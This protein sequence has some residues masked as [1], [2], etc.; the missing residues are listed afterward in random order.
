MS[1]L[2]HVAGRARNVAAGDLYRAAA[3]VL[4]RMAAKDGRL[5]LLGG[6]EKREIFG[7]VD[8]AGNRSA[9][10]IR[11]DRVV[12]SGLASLGLIAPGEDGY[13]I[14][15]EGVMWLRRRDAGAEP[16][17]EQHQD[18]HQ[19]MLDFAGTMR[20]VVMNAGE[21]PI[22]WLRR[23]KDRQGNALI[24]AAQ[25]EAG[26]RLRADYERGQLAPSTTSNW[27]AMA[28]SRRQRRSAPGG[29]SDLSDAALAARERFARALDAVG[30]ELSGVLIDICCHLAGLAET[31]KNNG[32]P[33]RSG[34]VILQLALSQ[35]ARH[36]GIEGQAHPGN[37]KE[38]ARLVHW[39]DEGYR[40]TLER[41]R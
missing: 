16:F 40:P 9:S 25:F 24:S 29:S 7:L 27:E 41:W 30:P 32:W 15:R 35:L 4:P 6:E 10:K 37:G 38:N 36:Y 13:A 12:V 33:Q 28:P 11:V 3:S 5:C 19:Q 14:T 18:R 8:G 34:K 1:A 17:I 21:S 23:R 26:E 22:G 20:P 39:G 2:K 31:E